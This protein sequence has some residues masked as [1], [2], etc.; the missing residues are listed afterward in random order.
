MKHALNKS[1]ALAAALLPSF[2][3]VQARA[4]S[5]WGPGAPLPVYKLA[6]VGRRF[7]PPSLS[8]PAGQKFKLI[9][10]NK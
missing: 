8:V 2:I 10:S 3:S 4:F 6:I 1:I 9:V 5:L 7:D